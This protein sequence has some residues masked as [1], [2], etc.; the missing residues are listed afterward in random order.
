[1]S[2]KCTSGSGCVLHT[3]TS[4]IKHYEDG[5]GMA[6]KV[7]YLGEYAVM[8]RV[9]DA[10]ETPTAALL[11]ILGANADAFLTMVFK[12]GDEPLSA[13]LELKGEALYSGIRHMETHTEITPSFGLDDLPE[14]ERK[15]ELYHDGIVDAIK[16]SALSLDEGL[17]KDQYVKILFDS[18]K[19]LDGEDLSG[20][21]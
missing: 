20:L 13:Y 18:V 11:R 10:I 9:N 14:A 15:A 21:F 3:R 19:P 5:E 6:A 8:T 16:A 12:V 2:E 17:T 1:M 7:T 4:G